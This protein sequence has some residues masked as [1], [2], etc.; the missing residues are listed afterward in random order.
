MERVDTEMLIKEVENR[1]VLWDPSFD[2]YKNKFKKTEAWE[3]ICT[4]FDPTFFSKTNMEKKIQVIE[5]TSKWRTVRDN[6]IR[7][8]KK[9]EE[10]E[11]TGGAAKRH[12]KYT[13]EPLLSFLKK[14]KEL[15]ANDSSLSEPSSQPST[16]GSISEPITSA[17]APKLEDIQP[18]RIGL[19]NVPRKATQQKRERNSIENTF[20]EY[21]QCVLKKM[22]SGE[23]EDDNMSFFR[24]LM[25]EI[26]ELTS[27]EKIKFRMG[28]MQLLLDIK[29]CRE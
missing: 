5:I 7:S 27:N 14:S 23:E 1:P 13:Y 16:S 20:E 15:R 8:L 10:H 19:Q 26:K 29:S 9:Q 11:K 2:E 21:M 25:P 4:I 17:F 12:S 22:K 28:V 6:Y 24:S 18:Q 3:E